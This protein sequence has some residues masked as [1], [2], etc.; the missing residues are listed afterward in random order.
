MGIDIGGAFTI[1]GVSGS[2]AFEITGAVDA[3]IIDTTGRSFLPNQPGFCA[4]YP[5]DVGWVAQPADTWVYQNYFTTTTYAKGYSGSRFTAPVAGYYLFHVYSYHNKASSAAGTGW[6][7]PQIY[8]NGGAP[9]PHHIVGHPQPVG[10]SFCA[11]ESI[12]L[13][14]A[15]GDYADMYIYASGAGTNV[16][17]Y[18]SGFEGYLVG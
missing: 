17:R 8:I 7:Y 14:M 2:Q 3:L 1:T 6:V 12:I 4:G 11:E 5:T 10:Y 16:Y 9:G 13:N 15:A 18:Y